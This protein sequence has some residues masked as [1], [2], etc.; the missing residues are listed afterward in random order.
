GP[1]GNL[2]FTEN[3]G[4]KIGQITPTGEIT[5]LLLAGNRHQEPF[6][7]TSGPDA[8]L[9]FTENEAN[10]IGRIT[11]APAPAAPLTPNSGPPATQVQVSGSGYG[12]FE[13][14]IMTFVDSVTGKTTL[15]RVL[16]DASGKFSA[17]VTIPANA[18]VGPQTVSVRA[19]I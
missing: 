8:N 16:T 15:G 2:W 10:T 5:E 9:W 4:N 1:D 13:T 12:S 17:S 18:T 7:I 11:D 3:K 14:V 19:T 6:S